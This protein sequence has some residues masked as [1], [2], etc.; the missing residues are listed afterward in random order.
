M[1]LN[2]E[3]IKDV[4]MVVL[5]FKFLDIFFCPCL[6][7]FF[8][9]TLYKHTGHPE[10]VRNLAKLFIEEILGSSI[11][12]LGEGG[13]TYGFIGMHFRYD[14]GDFLSENFLE[15]DVSIGGAR[16]LPGIIVSDIQRSLATPEYRLF[17]KHRFRRPI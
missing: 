17:L 3:M 13:V 4:Y 7:H 11:D 12:G 16:G 10:F 1:R 8:R 6:G 9:T 2:Q 14:L 5:K 15:K